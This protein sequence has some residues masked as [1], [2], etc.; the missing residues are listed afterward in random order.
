MK[1]T[2]F[3][4]QFHILKYQSK[5]RP[6]SPDLFL[7]N[8]YGLSLLEKISKSSSLWIYSPLWL[9]FNHCGNKDMEKWKTKFEY[10]IRMSNSETTVK[11]SVKIFF[12]P[13]FNHLY[14]LFAW[15]D[16]P[17]PCCVFWDRYF[18]QIFKTKCEHKF[19]MKSKRTWFIPSMNWRVK[20]VK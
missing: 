11:I 2:Y 12:V 19:C 13:F 15:A 10:R 17:W 5:P 9:W 7:W 1:P 4:T 20:N 16:T 3:P 8:S 6:D 14:Y 18:F